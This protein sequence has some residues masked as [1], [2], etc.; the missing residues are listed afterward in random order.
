[1][2]RAWL[3][4]IL[5]CGGCQTDSS[6]IAFGT[7]EYDLLRLTA[8][9]NEI[10]TDIPVREGQWVQAGTLVVQQDTQRAEQRLRLA[11]AQW[12]EAAAYLA[13]LTQ[14]PRSQTIAGAQAQVQ[15]ASAKARHAAAQAAR[16]TSLG[17]ANMLSQ[18][19]LDALQS[20][21]A[22]AEAQLAAAQ[23][24]LNLL[25]AGSR[26]EQLAQA[27]ARLDA[28]AAAV[29]LERQHLAELTLRAPSDGQIDSLPYR[30]GER[31]ATGALLGTLLQGEQA[32]ARLYIPEQQRAQLAPGAPLSLRISGY[33]Q[34]VQGKIRS[35]AQAPA[36]TPYF[37][38][39]QKERA[40]LVYLTEVS[41]PPGDKKMPAG[42]PVQ[43]VLP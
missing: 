30:V 39:N 4:L 1:M 41:L 35:I 28:A 33:A 42:L 14:G 7:T 17:R 29:A 15:D 22:R 16:G 24:N 6:D 20:E 13:E 5:M 23:Q 34:P 9:A 18:S 40:R 38:L 37:A 31:V 8:T 26:N 10:I 19:E 2:Q 36:F 43:W 27:R 21:R 32:Y 3:L 11:E 25:Q 12:Q